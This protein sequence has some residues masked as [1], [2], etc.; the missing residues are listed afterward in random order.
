MKRNNIEEFGAIEVVL[1]SENRARIC[2]SSVSS[3][4]IISSKNQC[5]CSGGLKERLREGYDLPIF[6]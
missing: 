3:L 1:F 4:K 6:R 5:A 2:G